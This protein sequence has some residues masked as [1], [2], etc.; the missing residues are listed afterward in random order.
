MSSVGLSTHA[1][2]DD[3]L[4]VVNRRKLKVLPSPPTA[5]SV[6]ISTTG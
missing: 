3:N 5:G 1:T 6:S 2:V 4:R